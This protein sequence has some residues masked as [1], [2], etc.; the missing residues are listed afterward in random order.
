MSSFARGLQDE[1]RR[2]RPR[3]QT[4]TSARGKPDAFAELLPLP[5]IIF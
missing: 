2:S 3:I 5:V 1:L 4:P